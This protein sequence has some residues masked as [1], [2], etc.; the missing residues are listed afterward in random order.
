MKNIRILRDVA[1]MAQ[2]QYVSFGDYSVTELITP[3]RQVQLRKRYGNMASPELTAIVAGIMGTAVHEYFEKMLRL[4]AV[5]DPKYQLERSVLDSFN[6]TKGFELVKRIV[7]GRF[8]VL[9]DNKDMYDIKTANV[10]KLIFDPDMIEWH[11]QQNLYAYL[12]H[13]R[14]VDVQSI[15]IVAVY[16]DWKEGN[17]LRD[18][19]YPQ[20]QVE[21]YKLTLWPIEQTKEYLHERL[22]LH[23]NHEDVPDNELTPCTSEDR[24]DRLASGRIVEYAVMKNPKAKRAMRVLASMDEAVEYAKT[25]KTTGESF[26]EVRHGV[27]KKCEK[28]CKIK[29]FCNQYV[30]Y[31]GKK[32]HNKLNDIIM[33]SEL[34]L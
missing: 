33:L 13:R 3:P 11:Q 12:L 9:Y 16:K 17:A 26:I 28:Y 7:S 20:N 27:R 22:K 21:E 24:W 6:T 29:D 8:D 25:A 1:A 4:Y 2:N 34:G 30:E 10:W 18:K 32:K 23:V 14:G 31:A 19:T 5:L 15:N